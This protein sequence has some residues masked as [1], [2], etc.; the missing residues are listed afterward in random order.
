[1]NVAPLPTPSLCSLQRSAQFVG[2]V[3]TTVQAKTV[4]LFLRSES[5]RKD[6][7]QV[8]RRD[9]HAIVRDMNLQPFIILHRRAQG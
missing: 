6:A 4:P 5:V 2:R 8:L 1:M 9:S 7:R 3:C